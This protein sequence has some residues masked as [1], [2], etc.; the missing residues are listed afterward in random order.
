MFTVCILKRK[1]KQLLLTYLTWSKSSIL[2]V[3]SDIQIKIELNRIKI[4]YI[5]KIIYANQKEMQKVK[6]GVWDKLNSDISFKLN[7]D[8]ARPWDSSYLWYDRCGRIWASEQ[9][10]YLKTWLCGSAAVLLRLQCCLWPRWWFRH[11]L[12]TTLIIKN[13]MQRPVGSR[14][15]CRRHS[16]WFPLVSPADQSDLR[17]RHSNREEER[18]DGEREEGA[19]ICFKM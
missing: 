14:T 7:G 9:R 17:I 12:N 4:V 16:D 13:K 15:G 2:I 6:F 10:L 11:I 5:T 3:E 18:G 19:Q 1:E 8:K